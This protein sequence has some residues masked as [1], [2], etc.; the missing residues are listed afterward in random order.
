MAR[1]PPG[2]KFLFIFREIKKFGAEAENFIAQEVWVL[3]FVF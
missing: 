2:G 3:G 1:C